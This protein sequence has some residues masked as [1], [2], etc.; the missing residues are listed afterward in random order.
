MRRIQIT[1]PDLA[2]VA[3][4]LDR[5]RRWPGMDRELLRAVSQK[6]GGAELVRSDE[7]T[8]DVITLQSRVRV[9]DLD[10]GMDATYLLVAPTHA[11]AE[12]GTISVLSPMGA[13]LLGCREGDTIEC[14][15]PGG[16]SRLKVVQLLYQPEAAARRSTR[17]AGNDAETSAPQG[18]DES[19][20]SPLALA[21]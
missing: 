1:E 8:R 9:K 11:S 5:E 6:V 13:A 20:P 16:P 17:H 15:V 19:V 3:D 21:G 18:P 10:T 2:R 14:R 4:L 12:A 7:I